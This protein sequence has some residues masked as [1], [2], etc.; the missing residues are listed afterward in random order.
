M[1]ENSVPCDTTVA[2]HMHI[3]SEQ[4][5]TYRTQQRLRHCETEEKT[6]RV[7]RYTVGSHYPQ[8]FRFY[9]VSTNM[10]PSFL[11]EIQG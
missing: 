1:S 11:G 2:K 8:R 5:Y 10:A 6:R 4:I 7:E 9:E 3:Q